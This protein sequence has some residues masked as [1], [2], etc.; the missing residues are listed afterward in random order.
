MAQELKLHSP[1][2]ADVAVYEWPLPASV[3]ASLTMLTN[4][5]IDDSQCMHAK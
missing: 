2:G 1:T 3:S 4:H 5:V